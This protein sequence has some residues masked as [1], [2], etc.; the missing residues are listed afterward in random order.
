MLQELTRSLIFAS[1]ARCVRKLSAEAGDWA[2]AGSKSATNNSKIT[3]SLAKTIMGKLSNGWFWTEAIHTDV[4]LMN[5]LGS[6]MRQGC[7]MRT[8]LGERGMRKILY[9]ATS[10][11]ASAASGDTNVKTAAGTCASIR[12][13]IAFV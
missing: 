11:N 6:S 8:E 7:L 1:V 3:L 5:G 12:R 2:S 9:P 4:F 10:G 13:L